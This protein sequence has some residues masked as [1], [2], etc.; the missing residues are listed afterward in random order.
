[1]LIVSQPNRPHLILIFFHTFR[2]ALDAAKH[3]YAKFKSLDQHSTW[4][5]ILLVKYLVGSN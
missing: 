5:I 2:Y 3:S 1:M 4:F